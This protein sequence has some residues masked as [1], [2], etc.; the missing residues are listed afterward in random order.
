MVTPNAITSPTEEE[1]F[2][3]A[4][5]SDV[6]WHQVP[7][8]WWAILGVDPVESV[9]YGQTRVPLSTGFLGWSLPLVLERRQLAGGERETSLLVIVVH[10][11]VRLRLDV[12]LRPG[13]FY[14]Q[15]ALINRG[16]GEK[17]CFRSQ[18][19]SGVGVLLP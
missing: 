10:L 4:I 12:P 1:A 6:S 9:V 13:T 14:T 8:E 5:P 16:G 19:D 3:L 15:M 2:S 17:Q 18:I 7:L 11:F